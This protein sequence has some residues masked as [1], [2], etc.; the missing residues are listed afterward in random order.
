MLY[1]G[2]AL[3]TTVPF[4]LTCPAADTSV[5]VLR[6]MGMLAV[7]FMLLMVDVAAIATPIGSLA[8]TYPQY[9]REATLRARKQSLRAY[10]ASVGANAFPEDGMFGP[11]TMI[12]YDRLIGDRL[13]PLDGLHDL[14]GLELE[15][16]N[17]RDEDLVHI[18]HLS[19]LTGLHLGSTRI[20]DRGMSQLDQLAN[21]EG[22]NLEN[23]AITDDGLQH[24]RGLKKL[25]NLNVENTRITDLS[26]PLLLSL[27]NLDSLHVRGT[28]IT[29]EGVEELQRK[30]GKYG[31]TE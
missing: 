21:L 13:K 6:P 8:M 18:A 24:I 1:G 26:I 17:A 15:G 19:K 3:A 29:P 10:W 28:S 27:P 7:M 2:T 31:V 16:T 30:L 12:D 5:G 9:H 22:L 25:R 11:I 20:T 23:T 14:E 4:V